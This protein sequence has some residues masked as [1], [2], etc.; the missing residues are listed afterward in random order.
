MKRHRVASRRHLKSS[1]FKPP[2]EEPPAEQFALHD[3]VTHDQYGLGDVIAVEGDVA[4]LVD[5][6]PQRVRIT[7]PFKSM[8]KL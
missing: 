2:P 7:A 5:F 3:K 8:T 4:V 6:H 1:P